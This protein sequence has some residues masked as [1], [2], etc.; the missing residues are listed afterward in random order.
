MLRDGPEDAA[1]VDYCR[2]IQAE[3]A[4]STAFGEPVRALLDLK[5]AKAATKRWG[6][7]KKGAPLVVEVGPRDMAAGAV[8]AVRRD[9]LYRDDGKLDARVMQR[10]A[11]V[12]EAPAL[13]GAIQ[14]SLHADAKSRLEAAIVPAAD[15]AAVAAIFAEGQDNS[16]WA[17]VAWSRPTGAALDAVIERL[18]ALRLTLRNAPL[19][20]GPIDSPCVF[21]GAPAVEHVLVA[22]AY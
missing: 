21:T 1:L 8:S 7:I 18:K 14:A 4:A 6:W 3:L 16:G 12:A 9:A 20:Q 15:W 11:F 17:Q 22:R 2:S 13:L 19:T 10:E 5:P